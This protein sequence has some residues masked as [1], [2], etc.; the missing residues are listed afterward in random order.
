MFISVPHLNKTFAARFQRT[1][2]QIIHI[3]GVLQVA[4][5]VEIFLAVR[6]GEIFYLLPRFAPV[7]GLFQHQLAR[8]HPAGAQL[9]IAPAFERLRNALIAQRT[10]EVLA[11]HRVGQ[12]EFAPDVPGLKKVKI[13][14]Q[15]KFIFAGRD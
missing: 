9:P 12:R 5:R 1:D 6:A 10:R 4:K 14:F 11:F 15:Q 7:F 3:G 8:P 13:A 2:P